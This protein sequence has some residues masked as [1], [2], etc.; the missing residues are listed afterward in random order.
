MARYRRR[1]RRAPRR[2]YSA[3]TSR[4]ARVGGRM[5]RARV[6]YNR[7]RTGLISL[8]RKTSQITTYSTPGAAGL[9]N[10]NDP[11]GTC[12]S[13]GTPAYITGTDNCYDI[14][15]SMVFRLDQL[16]NSTD[17]TNLADQYKIV[18]AIVKLHANW[19]L[20][21]SSQTNAIPFVEYI[22]DHDDG[23]VP[24]I[25]L[26]REKMGVKTKYFGTSRPFILMGVRP[27][28]ADTIFNNGLTSAYGVGSR[29]EWL[30]SQYPAVEHYAIKGVLHNVYLPGSGTGGTLFNW[31][32]SLKVVAKD[33]Q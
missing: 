9:I 8:V 5:R 15:F 31:D 29:K 1:I 25:S 3:P 10:K 19:N 7:N 14:P 21:G 33:F 2:K 13:L 27:R 18:S 22:Q 6:Q 12:L 11:T 16:M 28:F 30:N 24:A 4:Y 23:A 26:I 20:A 32:V 17:I